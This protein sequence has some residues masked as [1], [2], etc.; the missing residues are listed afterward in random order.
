MA[1]P[2]NRA[3]W[4]D[5]SK[6]GKKLN[7]P[8]MVSLA[9]ITVS[10]APARPQAASGPSAPLLRSCRASGR[11]PPGRSSYTPRIG[12][13][14]PDCNCVSPQESPPENRAGFLE[15][16]A[17]HRRAPRPLASKHRTRALTKAAHAGAPGC[18]SNTG[19]QV[20]RYFA[21][22]DAEVTPTGNAVTAF[23]VPVLRKRAPSGFAKPD[24]G[25]GKALERALKSLSCTRAQLYRL[26]K[27]SCF[28][29]GHDFSRAVKNGLMRAFHASSLRKS[30]LF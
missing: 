26:R 30:S 15:Q 21:P 10:R 28:V 16:Q 1:N 17:K 20:R 23:S 5:A 7:S 4:L 18:R 14:K 12:R 2:C 19:G 24:F 3:E 8:G 25:A 9:T 6:S 29:S 11:E 27:N 13:K 22:Y